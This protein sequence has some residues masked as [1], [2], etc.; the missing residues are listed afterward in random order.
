MMKKMKIRKYLILLSLLI[1]MIWL[2]SGK[3]YSKATGIETAQKALDQKEQQVQEMNQQLKD[4]SAE[5]NR[6]QKGI[7]EK[8]DIVNGLENQLVTQ[9]EEEK[10]L[11]EN[12]K[13]RI[14]FLYE[15][16]G[17]SLMEKM[18][19]SKSIADFLN[20]VEYASSIADYDR[21]M[22][23][24]YETVRGQI[25]ENK[26][27]IQIEQEL[28]KENQQQCRDKE[29]EIS[30]SVKQAQQQIVLSKEELV[31]LIAKAQEKEKQ[32]E[33]EIAR[34]QQALWEKIQKEKEKPVV[35]ANPQPTT[36]P[37]DQPGGA[38]FNQ[39]DENLLAALIEC[40]AGG[41]S[42]EGKIAVGSVVMNRVD[43]DRFQA[44]TIYGIIYQ[45]G[46]FAPA[47]GD[48]LGLTLLKGATPSCQQAAKEV[49]GGRRNVNGLFFKRYTGTEVGTVIGNHVF[50]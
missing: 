33:A 10:I 50:Y 1:G 3:L 16:G 25:Q 27:N 26:K 38:T 44:K 30:N 6:L 22:L 13:L 37:V 35:P 39:S 21:Q 49:L 23:K 46:Q 8:Q 14:Q 15:N 20:K 12:M 5:I 24:R 43:S 19:E 4:V 45:P 31:T 48:S 7:K 17:G 29:Q 18:L 32:L 28:M 11:H 9:N 2:G 47:M 42:Y 36:P 34:K 41:E 40:E